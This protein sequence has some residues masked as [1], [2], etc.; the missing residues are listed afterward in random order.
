MGAFTLNHRHR[1]TSG[2][3]PVGN[4]NPSN[5]KILLVAYI[6]AYKVVK[7]NYPD[8]TNFEGNK[9]LVLKDITLE[10]LFSL[11]DLDPHFQSGSPKGSPFARFEPTLEGWKAAVTLAEALSK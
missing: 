6:G 3:Q 9:I 11:T 1:T 2:S 4:P 10:E 5:F 8:C 7:V